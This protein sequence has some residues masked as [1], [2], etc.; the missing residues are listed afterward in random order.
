MTIIV[1]F[2]AGGSGDLVAR[3]F[4]KGMQS[5]YGS[6]FV[7]ENRGGAGGVIGTD[8]GAKA[9]ADGYTLLLG[10]ASTLAI[11]PS[12][13]GHLPYNPETAFA[14]ISPLVQFAN[15]LI[16]NNKIPVKNVAEFV[17]YMKGT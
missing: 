9:P 16:V 6:S 5:K 3:L 1:P 17:A 11:N 10:T 12:V 8:M 7:V 4:A 15:L 2:G 14:P 13:Y